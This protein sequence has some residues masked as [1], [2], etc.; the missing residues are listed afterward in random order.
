MMY[1]YFDILEATTTEVVVV[2]PAT[3][4]CPPGMIYKQCGPICRM[5]CGF[6]ACFS[7][8]CAPGCFC[9]GSMF[10]LQGRCVSSCPSE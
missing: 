1:V 3:P 4:T 10:E 8:R 6:N 5:T 2:T 7:L 9:P